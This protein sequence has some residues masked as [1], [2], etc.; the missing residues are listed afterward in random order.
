MLILVQLDLLSL[1]YL[2]TACIN[3]IFYTFSEIFVTFYALM[4]APSMPTR[5][6]LTAILQ[7]LYISAL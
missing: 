1:V 3:G 4:L 7:Q 5:W 2:Q 6:G